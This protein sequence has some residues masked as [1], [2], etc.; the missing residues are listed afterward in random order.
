MHAA[1]VLMAL[2][3][4]CPQQGTPT[5]E[6]LAKL[7]Q[8]AEAATKKY[9]D[10]AIRLNEM[11]GHIKSEN[12]ARAIVDSVTEMFA[13]EL[14]PDWATEGV[15]ARVA[16][17]E[18]MAVSSGAL[19]PEQRVADVWNEY[20]R[21]IGAPSEAAVAPAEIHHLRDTYYAT[22]VR[23]WERGW[24]QSIWTMPAIYALGADGKVASGC[25]TLEVLRVL[26][27]LDSNFENLRTAR[28][29]MQQGIVVSDLLQKQRE[30][31]KRTLDS[32]PKTKVSA[33]L[34][35][36]AVDNPVWTA[37]RRYIDEHGQLAFSGLLLKLFN[38][39]FPD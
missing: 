36:R 22:S 26:H 9:R 28:L 39:L 10:E 11:A 1:I 27:D 12:D 31:E 24:N 13:K 17:S 14:P 7:R 37:E 38:Q 8:E 3:A 15:R 29:Q 25:R 30:M 23:M 5:P 6:Q 18:F 4:G 2:L 20:V 33:R 32:S 19:I 16:H 34:E 21:E 35:T